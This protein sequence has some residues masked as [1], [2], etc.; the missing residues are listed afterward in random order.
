MMQQVTV[1]LRNFRAHA[2]LGAPMAYDPAVPLPSAGDIVE[3]DEQP[4]VCRSRH[5]RY[6]GPALVH[7]YLMV[8]P[9]DDADSGDTS[10]G[11][12]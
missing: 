9:D 11:H 1:E 3:V 10:N 8:E 4:Y 2:T 5:F 7:V 12:R 6:D